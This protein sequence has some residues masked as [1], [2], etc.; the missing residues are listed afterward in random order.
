MLDDDA[1][2]GE[3]DKAHRTAIGL[4]GHIPATKGNQ[5][6]FQW[7]H[8]LRAAEGNV[9]RGTQ[10]GYR[11][12]HGSTSGQKRARNELASSSASDASVRPC[13]MPP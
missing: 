3:G 9:S 8:N 7:A 6:G 2:S 5:N 1:A 13:E 12:T 4:R 11:C 10:G